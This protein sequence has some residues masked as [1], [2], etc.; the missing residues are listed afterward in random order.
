MKIKSELTKKGMTMAKCMDIWIENEH[1]YIK[2]STYALYLTIIEKHLKVYFKN[3][4]ISTISNKD[5]QSFILDKLNDGKLNGN[6]GLSRKTVKDMVT[7]LNAVLNFAI[8]RKIIKKT[9]FEYKIPKD[10][11]IEKMEVFDSEERMKIFEYIK[12]NMNCRTA[13][14][15]LC[16]CTGLRIGEICALRWKEVDMARG[17]ISINHTIQRIYLSN[18]KKS[19]VIISEPKTQSSKRKIPI[20]RELIPVLEKFK[21]E[22]GNYVIS[23][24]EK[25]IEPRTY[26]KF[27]KKMLGFLKIRKLRFHSLRHTFATQAIELGIDCKTVSEILGHSTVSIT[28]NLY[29]HPDL[30]H[31]KKCMN[32]IFDNM[33]QQQPK[34]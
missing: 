25:Y 14:I 28:L 6:G 34:D 4:K 23:G 3:R 16:L 13:G 31:K 26:R 10:E 22:D 9:Q 21:S 29:V 5:L 8:K 20:A 18:A 24:T 17:I 1:N 19:E 27:F 11:K 30:D 33:V 7:V 15:L 12:K 2:E 32:I